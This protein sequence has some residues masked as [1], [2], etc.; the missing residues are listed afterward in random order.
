MAEAELEA[1]VRRTVLGMLYTFSGDIIRDGVLSKGP[2]GHFPKG[3][4]F[5]D[6]MVLPKHRPAW[7]TDA[8]F[9]FYTKELRASGFRAGLNW[10]RNIDS[11]PTI[12]APFVGATIKQPA[13]YIYGE[14]DLIGGNRPDALAQ[15][16]AALPNLGPSCALKAP[17]IGFSRSGP[18]K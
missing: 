1:D 6:Q 5:I 9:D 8:D 2:D 4:R 12:V 17:A 15:M 14:H 18:K 11:I 16:Q 13:L 10:Y 7:V 3:E